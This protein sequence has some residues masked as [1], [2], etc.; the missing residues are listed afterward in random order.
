MQ[1]VSDDEPKEVDGVVSEDDWIDGMED[2]RDED[3]D[4]ARRQEQDL[5]GATT[6]EDEE[7]PPKPDKKPQLTDPLMG[8]PGGDERV[9]RDLHSPVGPSARA[10]ELHNYTHL[11]YRCWCNPCREARAREDA[12]A[13]LK[14]GTDEEELEGNALPIISLDYQELN[15]DA[16]PPQKVIVGK[17]E[18]TGSV[19]CHK[20]IAKGLTDE[21]AVRKVIQDIEDVGRSQVILKT[22][23]EPAIKAVQSRMIS[24]R[25]AQT[26]PRNPPAYNPQS[27]GPC[28]KAVQ[29][30]TGQLRTMKLAL[31]SRVQV[32]V[33]DDL[34]IMEWALEHACF[35]LNK[36]NVGHD[37]MT[38]HER[39]TG[40][41]WKRPIL[42]FGEAVMA[43]LSLQRRNKGRTRKQK[44]KLAPRAIP[45]VWVGQ[46][47]RTGEHI[48]I[49]ENGDAVRCRTVKRNAPEDRWLA[50]KVMLIKATPRCPAPSA[51]DLSAYARGPWTRS[52]RTR[53]MRS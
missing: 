12:H 35:L 37:G 18:K 23:G 7:Q 27:N 21:W 32:K 6:D 4:E 5:F 19:F 48:V 24:L 41:K 16:E 31:E 25:K 1:E 11:P 9:P 28:E 47:G 44:R 40:R 14:H 29:D 42:E 2:E 39:A 15:E 53:R 13:R 30:V 34:P 36:F 49:K 52:R 3:E 22:D 26:V 8:D 20:V 10:I 33:P 45:A 50:E 38:P 51:K 43:K 46:V 17:D